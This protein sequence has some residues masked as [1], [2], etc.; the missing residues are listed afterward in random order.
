VRNPIARIIRCVGV[1]LRFDHA[2]QAS[3]FPTRNSQRP[4]PKLAIGPGLAVRDVQPPPA[5]TRRATRQARLTCYPPT[6]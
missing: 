2:S 1:E 3:Q 5:R 6:A 4:T